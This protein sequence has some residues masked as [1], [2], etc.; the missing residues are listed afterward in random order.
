MKLEDSHK[1][2][3]LMLVGDGLSQIQVKTFTNILS[4]ETY[5]IFNEDH[6]NTV[7]IQ[8]VVKQVV[9]IRGDL[10]GGYFHFLQ[11]TYTLFFGIFVQP[12]QALLGWKII[13][14]SDVTTCYQQA[15]GLTIIMDNEM[16]I[17]LLA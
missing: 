15:A 4:N 12:V 17:H 11:A 16:E 14:G 5:S 13:N 1:N 6:E 9:N 8:K 3:S 7:I 2:Q 10:H